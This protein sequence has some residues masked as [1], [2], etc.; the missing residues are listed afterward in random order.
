MLEMEMIK[1]VLNGKCLPQLSPG[2]SDFNHIY[3]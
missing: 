3:L 2:T 1:N